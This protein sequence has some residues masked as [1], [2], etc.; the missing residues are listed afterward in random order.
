MEEKENINKINIEEKD[1]IPKNETIPC[2]FCNNPHHNIKTFSCNHKICPVCLFRRIFLLNIK[3]FNNPKNEIEIKC[4]CNQGILIKNIEELFEINNQKN[5]IYTEELKAKSNKSPEEN[6]LCLIHKDKKYLKY[7][8][9]CY[10]DLCEDCIS[11]NNNA[12]LNHS[13]FSNEYLINSLKKELSEIKL[14][15]MTKD[16]FEKKWNEICNKIKEQTQNNFDETMVKIEEVAQSIIDFRKDYEEKYK[17]E[18]TKI[19]KVLKLYKLFYLDY[20]LEKKQAEDTNNI[21]LLRYAKSIN[22][23][24]SGIEIKKDEKFYNKLENIKNALNDLKSEKINFEATFNFTDVSKNY[25]IEQIIEKSHDKLING[26]FEIDNNKII[27]GSLDYNLKIWEEKN[28]KF[29]NIKKIKGVCGAVCCMAKLNDGSLVTSAANNNNINI[30]GKQGDDNYVIKQ[31]LSSHNKPVLTLTQL[32]N[33]KIVSG[34]WDNLIIIWDKNNSGYYVEKQRIKDKKPIM[35]VVAL[36]NDK[37][38]F[39]SDNRIRIMIQKT[40]QSNLTGK[41]SGGKKENTDN[42]IIND[43][44]DDLEFDQEV[45]YDKDE[46]NSFI[47]C[48]K[49][50][51]HVGRV[52]CM[53]EL[54]NGYF[55]SGAGDTGKKKDNNILVWKPNDLDGFFYAQTLHGHQSDIN[56]LIE[57]KDGR[58]ASSSKD[59]TIRIWKSYLKE[60]KNNQKIINF[61]IDEILSEFKH[62]IYGIIQLNDGR[63]FSSSSEFSLVIWKDRR[64][65]SYD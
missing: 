30:W 16:D 19:V 42:E 9:E 15:F 37:F 58:V 53:L 20:Y 26:I 47:V 60:D 57:L 38:A 64:F 29:E 56:G 33:G 23:E 31:S 1:D 49:L 61:Q 2:N 36:K 10:K 21:N 4:K 7:C 65:L 22:S 59:R 13:I 40:K 55:L 27:T 44:F 17:N 12:H 54:K 24:L 6:I 35:K 63:I 41:D 46:E 48:Y 45:E 14:N 18:L 62:G 25:K 39:T 11:D 52:R 34:G 8:S 51:K 3:V 5:E 43:V 50:S 32:G 28:N